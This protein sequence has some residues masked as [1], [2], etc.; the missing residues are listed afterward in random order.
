MMVRAA[1]EI[2]ASRAAL[3]ATQPLVKRGHVM[4]AQILP[5][6]KRC[7]KCG[8]EKPVSDFYRHTRK[9]DGLMSCCRPC[10][11]A[12]RPSRAGE[13][14]GLSS[15]PPDLYSADPFSAL[16]VLFGHV[17]GYPGYGVDTDGNAWTCRQSNGLYAPEWR[18]LSPSKVDYYII[19]LHRGDKSYRSASI[20][21][22]VLETFMGPCPE[23]LQ[24]CHNDGDKANNRLRNLRR[25]TPLANSHDRVQHGTLAC[26]SRQGL[27][28]L[29]E[30]DVVLAR[31]LHERGES[32][33]SLSRRF[34]VARRTVSCAVRGLTWKH[35]PMTGEAS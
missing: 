11:T 2:R 16:Y 21:L 12:S 6:S 22:L 14:K 3:T 26:G 24:G 28:K 18:K 34:G 9:P 23:G 33:E 8:L 17:A 13:R 1:R 25:D 35:V 27:A 30:D 19:K 31:S 15:P 20:H 29:T 4:A 5:A 32:F 10:Y 7:S